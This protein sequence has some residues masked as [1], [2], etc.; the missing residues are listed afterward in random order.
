MK[1][2]VKVT[3]LLC[4]CLIS[5]KDGNK[6]R[7]VDHMSQ[8]HDTRYD[9]ELVLL[10]SVMTQDERRQLLDEN[11]N[12]IESVLHKNPRITTVINNDRKKTKNILSVDQ[13]NKQNNVP[14]QEQIESN[15]REVQMKTKEQSNDVFD[16]TLDEDDEELLKETL[17]AL[18]NETEPTDDQV[19]E[20]AVLLQD[21]FDINEIGS[22]LEESLESNQSDEKIE[23]PTVVVEEKAKEGVLKCKTC[24][25]Y[26]K[27][28]L[29]EEHKI[30]HQLEDMNEDIS[31]EPSPAPTDSTGNIPKSEET[32]VSTDNISDDES[33]PLKVQKNP[34][35]EKLEKIVNK[36][37]KSDS[38]DDED[39]S[40][41]KESP[42]NRKKKLPCGQCRK[43]FGSKLALTSHERMAHKKRKQ[44]VLAHEDN[45][46]R[47]EKS[48]V[49][50]K[51]SESQD[52]PD[53][54]AGKQNRR[55]ISAQ[56]LN[57]NLVKNS[58]AEKN[59]S[60][61]DEEEMEEESKQDELNTADE[62]NSKANLEKPA[63]TSTRSLGLNLNFVKNSEPEKNDS[64]ADKDP[65]SEFE[66]EMEEEEAKQN[67]I[68]TNETLIRKE[69]NPSCA[70]SKDRVKRS[71]GLNLN[72]VKTQNNDQSVMEQITEKKQTSNTN[73]SMWSKVEKVK[74]TEAK[75]FGLKN[76][77]FVKAASSNNKQ[78]ESAKIKESNEKPEKSIGIGSLNFQLKKISVE[79][80][81]SKNDANKTVGD[82]ETKGKEIKSIGINALKNYK[83]PTQKLNL[84]KAP[85]ANALAKLPFLNLTKSKTTSKSNIND[86]NQEEFEEE[87]DRDDF[88]EEAVDGK[89]VTIDESFDPSKMTVSVV[90]T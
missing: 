55:A 10:I 33:L 40:A 28:S 17:E 63:K 45:V 52:K 7:F 31:S 20:A 77:N 72:L 54:N 86:K 5:C 13:T 2:G 84:T 58:E 43:S 47:P 68:D 23:T 21:G 46:Q 88:D 38:D 22:A 80:D 4:R 87:F 26:I 39:W 50:D 74:A 81:S 24:S 76:L 14:T 15:K 64:M 73:G 70:K 67:E 66:D 12:I 1:N 19:N 65:E 53:S 79:K 41:T 37:R 32:K 35:Q 8:E 90:C 69:K 75:S 9:F 34:N 60:H 29:M 85:S 49:D 82:Y 57:L 25:K 56:A 3:C 83:I 27:Q 48:I 62:I 36:K 18:D 11:Q 61:K 89:Q 78:N 59:D 16:L 51:Q 44:G 30:T 71:L 42:K 6:A